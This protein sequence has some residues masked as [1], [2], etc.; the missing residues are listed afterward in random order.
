VAAWVSTGIEEQPLDDCDK[1]ARVNRLV[2]GVLVLE[3]APAAPETAQ[4][5]DCFTRILRLHETFDLV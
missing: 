3:K 5:L 1:E 4:L 2:L